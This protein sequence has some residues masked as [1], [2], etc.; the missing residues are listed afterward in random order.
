VAGDPLE[1]IHCHIARPPTPPSERTPGIPSQI[2]AIILKLLGKT[3]EER[4]QTAKGLEAD[5]RRCL[6][7]WERTGRISPFPLGSSDV[8]DRLAIPE[9]L[10]G[11]TRKSR[12]W[13]RNSI[14][15]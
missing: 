6:A 10:Y 7:E 2:E 15:S 5:L 8:P 1:L 14:G 11:G 3:A 4:Y 12:C 13:Y 9:R